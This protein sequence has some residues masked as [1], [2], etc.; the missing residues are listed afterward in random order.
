MSKKVLIISASNRMHSNSDI[1]AQ[2]VQKGASDAGN[3]VEL[4]NLKGKNIGFCQGCLACQ[5]TLKC[6]IKDDMNELVEKV[7]KA[8]VLVLAT[9]IYYYE[10]SGQLKTFLDRCNPIYPTEYNFREVYLL[11]AS[12]DDGPKTYDN[13]VNGLKGWIICFSKARFAGL[14]AGGG[15]NEPNEIRK[16]P[17]LLQRAYDLGKNI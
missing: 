6:V 5:K 12:A 1:L 15:I 17:D 10:M 8:D 9:P 11:A 7:Q 14:L 16:H 13:A 2:E 4:V 3:D